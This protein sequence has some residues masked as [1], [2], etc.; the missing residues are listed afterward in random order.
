MGA[1]FQQQS[2]LTPCHAT[3]R[4]I[5][6]PL[7][8]AHQGP[9]KIASLGALFCSRTQP[10][11]CHSKMPSFSTKLQK[12]CRK[13]TNAY[14]LRRLHQ[15]TL[16][17]DLCPETRRRPAGDPPPETRPRRALREAPRTPT[18]HPGALAGDLPGDWPGETPSVEPPGALPTRSPPTPPLPPRRP[19]LGV[20][21]G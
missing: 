19:L 18:L 1:S 4:G 6:F 12:T 9:P 3:P 13:H 11:R 2:L 21:S 5:K 8:G 10:R 16:S 17:G 7:L 20:L 14:F 15:E